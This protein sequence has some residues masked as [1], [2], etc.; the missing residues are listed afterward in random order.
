MG[1]NR[2]P[3]SKTPDQSEGDVEK[4]SGE[5][6]PAAPKRDEVRERRQHEEFMRK[7]REKKRDSEP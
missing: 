1:L 3:K 4:R 6:E 2:G 7:W 5:P